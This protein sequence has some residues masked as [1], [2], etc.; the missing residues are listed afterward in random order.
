MVSTPSSYHSSRAWG[1]TKLVNAQIGIIA[2]AAIEGCLWY[3]HI[4]ALP[5]DGATAAQRLPVR[6]A[7]QLG[8]IVACT[9][10]L[11][12]RQHPP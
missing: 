7:N 6:L 9:L 12:W 3:A 5:G 10:V 8:A 11:H 4:A 1:S 2:Q